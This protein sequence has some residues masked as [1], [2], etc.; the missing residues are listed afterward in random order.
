MVLRTPAAVFSA[1]GLRD[2]TLKLGAS[3]RD[4]PPFGPT[5]EELLTLV[6]AA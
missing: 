6:S 1:P 3:W 4:A 5:R 2:K